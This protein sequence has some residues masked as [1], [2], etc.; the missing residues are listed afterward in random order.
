MKLTKT[1]RAALELIA[2][3]ANV[4]AVTRLMK[5]MR[6]INGNLE[7][8]LVQRGLIEAVNHGE[9]TRHVGGKDHTVMIRVWR[10]TDAGKAALY[11]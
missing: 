3:G 6:R 5:D 2:Q 4:E 7:H 11:S 8:S 10:L 1:A 9:M